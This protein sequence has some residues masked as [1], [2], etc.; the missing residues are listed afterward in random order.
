MKLD[1]NTFAVITDGTLDVAATVAKFEE[2]LV[3][4]AEENSSTRASAAEA[5]DKL[6][7]SKPLG[8]RLNSQFIIVQCLTSMGVS[9]QA[10][11]AKYSEAIVGY[12][13]GSGKYNGKRGPGGGFARNV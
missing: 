8:T 6:F 12:L 11:M 2:T 7:D 5:V 4:W 9:D 10:E 3:G 13:Q 1:L